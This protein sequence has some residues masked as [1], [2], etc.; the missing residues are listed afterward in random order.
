MTN[1][2]K[3]IIFLK[4]ILNS[5]NRKHRT[6]LLN[7]YCKQNNFT[8]LKTVEQTSFEHSLLREL[9]D[10]I[11]NEIEGSVTIL[12]EDKLLNIPACI[13]LFTMLGTL[14]LLNLI[15]TELYKTSYDKIELYGLIQDDFLSIATFCLNYYL[16]FDKVV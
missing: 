14:H 15:N 2:K 4:P 6:E 8:I 1:S 10:L 5:K 3:I 12:V 7:N 13:T 16:K 11:K 9:I